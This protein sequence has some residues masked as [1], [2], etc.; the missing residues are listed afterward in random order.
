M[1]RTI[2]PGRLRTLAAL[3]MVVC[4]EP[5][6]ARADHYSL[7]GSS[8]RMEI[9]NGLV[10]PYT[11]IA[12]PSGAV[13][14]TVLAGVIQTY[15][16][17]VPIGQYRIMMPK[18]IFSAPKV[19]ST[20]AMF[21]AN[22]AIFQVRTNIGVSFPSSPAIFEPG[23]RLGAQTVRYCPGDGPVTAPYSLWEPNCPGPAAGAF[24]GIMIYNGSVSQFG[25]AA[26]ASFTGTAN[27]AVVLGATPAACG[28]GCVV[29]FA[30][31]TPVP[32]PGPNTWGQTA[33][34]AH[35]APNPGQAN[36]SATPGGKINIA[37]P[38]AAAGVADSAWTHFGPWTTGQ[39]V[40]SAPLALGGVEKFTI[41]GLD[42]RIGGAGKIQLVSASLS[43]RNIAGINANR[44][45]LTMDMSG[46]PRLGHN[47]APSISISGMISLVGL[48]GLAG[49]F[50]L[51][52]KRALG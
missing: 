24:N 3:L 20:I 4:M 34:I 43:L 15:V 46:G 22:P 38:I 23:G 44:S 12:A 27:I 21:N 18:G 1:C 52:R 17:E 48:M 31:A 42:N 2:W 28:A 29:G 7:V 11:P 25:G 19:P 6:T 30:N 50:W 5:T 32:S 41:T 47:S 8:L 37:I 36:V 16:N 49:G 33:A 39:I 26:G 13:K 14:Q 10:V 45:W 40:V 9:G 51:R 35:A